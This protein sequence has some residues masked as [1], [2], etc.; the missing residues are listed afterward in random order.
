MDTPSFL[1]SLLP[2]ERERSLAALPNLSSLVERRR[3]RRQSIHFLTALLATVLCKTASSIGTEWVLQR[4]V[5]LI[6]YQHNP[7]QLV[8]PIH[9]F[10]LTCAGQLSTTTDGERISE[11]G[12]RRFCIYAIRY[13][14][15][16]NSLL[17]LLLS[18]ILIHLAET[19]DRKKKHENERGHQRREK[20]C[21]N[22]VVSRNDVRVSYDRPSFRHWEVDRLLHHSRNVVNHRLEA[23]ETVHFFPNWCGAKKCDRRIQQEEQR[24]SMCRGNRWLPHPSHASVPKPQRLL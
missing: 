11:C 18:C 15:S 8:D 7:D 13:W 9:P 16:G 24:A 17:L 21:D 2:R 20:G 10:G 23:I 4:Y 5:L 14:C 12:A 6:V 3:R 1:L 19:L 22:V